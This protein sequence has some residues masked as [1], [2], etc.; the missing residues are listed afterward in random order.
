MAGRAGGVRIL[1][2]VSFHGMLVRRRRNRGRA[3]R[4]SP[5][6]GPWISGR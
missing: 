3:L 4:Q 2:M 5:E 1:T 6:A